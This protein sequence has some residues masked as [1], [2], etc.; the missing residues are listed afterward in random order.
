[1]KNKK[2]NVFQAIQL[3][4]FLAIEYGVRFL[5]NLHHTALRQV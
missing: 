2:W 5:I 1:M 3:A 4:M